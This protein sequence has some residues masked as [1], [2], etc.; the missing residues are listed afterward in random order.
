MSTELKSFVPR[1]DWPYFNEWTGGLDAYKPSPTD[2][3]AGKEFDL[4]LDNGWV[5]RHT[6]H[7]GSS[8]TWETLEGQGKGER[9]TEDYEAFEIRPDIYLFDFVK[10][11]LFGQNV[12]G[13]IELATGRV[14]S[15]LSLVSDDEQHD[16]TSI[17]MHAAMDRPVEELAVPPHP[18]T[19]ALVGKR[20]LF[21]YSDHH[22]YEH[23]YLNPGAFAWHCLRGP[24]A[25]IG[26]TE[27]TRTFEIAD[28]VY[29][30]LFSE[31]VM[32]TE[33]VMIIDIGQM[34]NFGRFFGWDAK[35]GTLAHMRFGARGKLLNE[36]SYDLS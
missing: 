15:V 22:A 19:D 34:R 23:I 31:R 20:I 6:F 32:P 2:A 25:G 36:T 12:T 1:A 17:L 11:E 14:T 7:D 4:H 16:T 18:E 35:D 10:R 9:G 33:S 5:I 28:Q 3:L 21:T 8:V 13:V 29:L 26:D 30:F 24:E 27:E